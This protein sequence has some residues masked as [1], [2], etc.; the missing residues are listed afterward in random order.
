MQMTCVKKKQSN[1]YLFGNTIFG[2]DSYL[3]R[4]LKEYL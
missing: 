3:Q 4:F 2:L 1:I